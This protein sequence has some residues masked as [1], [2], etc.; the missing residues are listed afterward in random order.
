M[1]NHSLGGVA[2]ADGL[3]GSA[4]VLVGTLLHSLYFIVAERVI[5]T[6]SPYK[7]VA[8]SGALE[9][10]VMLT[11]TCFIIHWYTLDY[12]LLEPVREAS[13]SLQSIAIGYAGLT[14]V[15]LL[16]HVAFFSLL[17]MAV[18]CACWWC[19]H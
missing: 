3:W 11:Y 12:T 6:M 7:F 2:A 17:G 16:H 18:P 1:G 5:G 4:M 9:A 8:L 13:G 10:S 19:L 15:N 14:V